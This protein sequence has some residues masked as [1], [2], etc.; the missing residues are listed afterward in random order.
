MS[1][2]FSIIIPVYNKVDTLSRSIESV[3]HQ[4]FIDFELIIVD[5]GSTDNSPNLVIQYAN[6][7][8][9]IRY[10]RQENNG[11][12]SARNKGIVNALGNYVCFLDA[13]DEVGENWLRHFKDC[14]NVQQYEIVFCNM[15]IHQLDGKTNI[16]NAQY[17][18]RPDKYDEN[19]FFQAGTFTIQ[20][21]YLNRAGFFD[22]SIRF[23]EFTELSFRCRSLGFSKAYT[24]KTDFT[25][26]ISYTGGGK[27]QINRIHSCLYL[28]N[29]HSW[30]FKLFPHVK[31]LYLQNIAVSYARLWDFKNARYYFFK[32]FLI[33]PLKAS[34]F[35]RFILSCFS[36]LAKRKWPLHNN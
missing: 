16:V 2:F 6:S 21:S 23:G 30:Y 32:A 12:C 15:L 24:N 25:Y 7:D 34:T 9:R 13:D 3:L 33:N 19:G 10:F 35:F 17:P 26:Y 8:D 18:F 36:F 1:P 29:K 11:V 20:R 27:N 31:R 22:E 14:L 28:L 5:D 4:T